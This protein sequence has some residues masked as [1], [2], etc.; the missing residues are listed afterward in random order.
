MDWLNW[1]VRGAV[2]LGGLVFLIC[3]TVGAVIIVNA[4]RDTLNMWRAKRK[5]LA[6]Q[7]QPM[8]FRDHL[9]DLSDKP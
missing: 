1:L 9:D 7:R 3:F 6:Y 4:W 5:W 8:G 2:V